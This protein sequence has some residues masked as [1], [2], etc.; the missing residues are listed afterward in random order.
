MSLLDI[1]LEQRADVLS[2]EMIKDK[3]QTFKM[4]YMSGIGNNNFTSWMDPYTSN[5]LHC[6]FCWRVVDSRTGS[7]GIIDCSAPYLFDTGEELP[8]LVNLTPDDKLFIRGWDSPELPDY[9]KIFPYT[10]S[11]EKV[12]WGR[13][14]CVYQQYQASPIIYLIDCHPDLHID[15]FRN[16]IVSEVNSRNF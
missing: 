6:K 12:M 10:G 5:T 7:M 8:M 4:V 3:I 16:I 2:R 1:D 15:G 9:I 13:E 14:D 11:I